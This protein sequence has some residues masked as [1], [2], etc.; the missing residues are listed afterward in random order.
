MLIIPSVQELV[1]LLKN[2]YHSHVEERGKISSMKTAACVRKLCPGM[3]GK[4]DH[5]ERIGEQE[6]HV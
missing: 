4:L 6:I 3:L 5:D 2:E 1:F